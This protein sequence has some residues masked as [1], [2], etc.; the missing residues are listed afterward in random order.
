VNAIMKS[1]EDILDLVKKESIEA[2][3]RSQ[4]AIILQPGAI[5]DCIVTLPLARFMKNQLHLGGVDLLSHTDYTSFMPG[6]SCIDSIRS[7]DSMPLHRLFAEPGEFEIADGDPL[8]RYFSDYS[9]LVTFLGQ[10]G[11]NFE[12]NLIFTVNCS[13]SAEVITLKLRP[14][15]TNKLHVSH[16][17]I[18]SFLDQTNLPLSSSFDLYQ[19]TIWA[20]SDDYE[21]GKKLLKSRG[22]D[23]EQKLLFIHP[24]SGGQQKCWP[25]ENYLALAEK[26]RPSQA[27][28]LFGPA[29]TESLGQQ[30]ISEIAGRFPCLQNLPIKNLLQILSQGDAFV[31]NDSGISHLAGS[32]GLN[33]TVIFG[34]TSSVVYR[35]VGPS[36]KAI[37]LNPDEF[38]KISLA[39]QNRITGLLNDQLAASKVS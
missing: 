38:K 16:F 13:H 4:R 27:I 39:V 8:M 33:T 26:I 6:R 29:E 17:H 1:H 15:E 34:P 19:K 28:F 32:L 3:R 36:V 30:R 20:S 21:N 9:W 35:P 11:G 24:G 18:R 31:G 5:G 25:V 7:L 10:A 37:S 14:S 23:L 12:E 2:A 22:I